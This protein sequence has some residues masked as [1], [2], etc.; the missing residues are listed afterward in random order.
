MAGV[1]TTRDYL[2]H[3]PAE[4]D[5]FNTIG[6]KTTAASR[7][8]GPVSDPKT[9]FDDAALTGSFCPFCDIHLGSRQFPSWVASRPWS[10]LREIVP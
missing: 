9:T 6:A 7:E 4:T 5:F 1:T 10:L 8:E 3:Q 2:S